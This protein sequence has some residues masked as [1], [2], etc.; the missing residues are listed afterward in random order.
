[1][2]FPFYWDYSINDANFG[3][4]RVIV[5]ECP[6]ESWKWGSHRYATICE[7]IQ[8]CPSVRQLTRSCVVDALNNLTGLS[9]FKETPA[10]KR[11]LMVDP[12]G[13]LKIASPCPCGD[14]DRY[15]WA[16]AGDTNPW[17]LDK[18]L[19][20]S[21]S[22]DQLYCIDIEKAWP[23]ILVFRPSWP[24]GPFINPKLPNADDCDQ[25][26][27]DVIICN[28]DGKREVDYRCEEPKTW[29]YCK[30]VFSGGESARSC[31]GKTI[32]YFLS[33]EKSNRPDYD[34]DSKLWVSYIKWD[35][36][37][38]G[39][40]AFGKPS[41][42]WVVR[43]T[44]P[45]VYLARFS[46]YS[47]FSSVS[48]A[49]RAGLWIDY[50]DGPQELND[51]KY[52]GQEYYPPGHPLHQKSPFNSTFPEPYNTAKATRNNTADGVMALNF[53]GL[54]FTST[55]TLNVVNAPVELY[56]CIK[57]D[58]RVDDARTIKANDVDSRY[59][60]SVGGYLSDAYS[61]PTSLEVVRVSD[62]I[63]EYKMDDLSL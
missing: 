7:L 21:C 33:P 41:S 47:N 52:Q 17:E 38:R 14:W 28:N 57:P 50:G 13:C 32:R 54:P 46:I 62:A 34:I 4:E 26:C 36:K 20:G 55:Y 19:R 1:M 45:W 15:V 3:C 16:T 11:F 43:I 42:Y 23:G 10:D 53:T 30:A 18:K 5:W 61:S 9:G 2:E 22:Y 37:V 12:N 58:M 6:D 63:P 60:I 51:V 56:L 8:N 49:T 25:N 39:T 40:S 31:K 27:M 24:N 29:E 44:K 35:W 48:W 59:F